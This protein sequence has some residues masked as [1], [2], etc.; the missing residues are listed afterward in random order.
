MKT[1]MDEIFKKQNIQIY[2]DR[3]LSEADAHK[4]HKNYMLQQSKGQKLADLA[5]LLNVPY[6]LLPGLLVEYEINPT[7]LY[8]K[9]NSINQRIME[10]L[11]KKIDHQ[12]TLRIGKYN[13]YYH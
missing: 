4:R 3:E 13:S 1:K 12:S 2:R 5:D 7:F 11:K 9:N 10:T 8:N 6:N